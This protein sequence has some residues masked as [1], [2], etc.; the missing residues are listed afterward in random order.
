MGQMWD[1]LISVSVHFGSQSQN[2]LK[3]ILKSPRFVPFFWPILHN[4]DATFDIPGSGDK[5]VPELSYLACNSLNIEN[6]VPV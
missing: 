3:L 6:I 4:L 5:F 1:F 2:V